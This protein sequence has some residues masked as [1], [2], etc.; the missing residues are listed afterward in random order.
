MITDNNNPNA[1]P[2]FRVQVIPFYNPSNQPFSYNQTTRRSFSRGSQSG[3]G[4][5]PSRLNLN[6]STSSTSSSGT[7]SAGSAGSPVK[8]HA[9]LSPTSLSFDMI[10]EEPAV[11]LKNGFHFE[12]YAAKQRSNSMFVVSGSA[13]GDGPPASPTLSTA[14]DEPA[15]ALAMSTSIPLAAHHRHQ[16]NYID[17]YASGGDLDYYPMRSAG[18]LA[19]GNGTAGG[20]LV[21]EPEREDFPIQSATPPD[22]A[23]KIDIVAHQLNK[24][25]QQQSLKHKTTAAV[26]QAALR[27]RH[28]PPGLSTG[29]GS[30]PR[31]ALL[32]RKFAAHTMS[33]IDL[34]AA[35]AVSSDDSLPT[36]STSAQLRSTTRNY[37]STY[38]SNTNLN[39]LNNNHHHHHSN[40]HGHG[41]HQH[42]GAAVKMRRETSTAAAT[43]TT[44]HYNRENNLRTKKIN[45]QIYE[46]APPKAPTRSKTSLDLRPASAASRFGASTTTTTAVA[47]AGPPSPPSIKRKSM[48]FG[49]GGG[50]GAAAMSAADDQA[51]FAMLSGEH[52]TVVEHLSRRHATLRLLK[53]F[54]RTADVT[55]ALRHAIKVNDAALLVDLFGIILETNAVAWTLDMCTMLL[56]ELYELLRSVNRL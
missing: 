10:E 4:A 54:A 46:S 32:S 12:S 5:G 44:S 40:G 26:T 35:S 18:G 27:R 55:E 21:V 51:A 53:Q 30:A 39:S 33:T 56:P 28:S 17:N 42:V 24:Q 52:E 23:P 25:Q 16:H 3:A 38:S 22:Y 41:H 48:H 37:S 14:S 31:V 9:D 29:A 13:G 2:P 15:P 47:A 8:S 49:G 1:I 50:G 11:I 20:A 43:S 7:G 36:V 34:A 19:L 45:V 6:K